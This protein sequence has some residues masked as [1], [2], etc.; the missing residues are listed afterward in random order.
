MLLLV[1]EGSGSAVEQTG[2]GAVPQRG[3]GENLA[4]SRKDAKV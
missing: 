4:Q 3:R 1:G 2:W